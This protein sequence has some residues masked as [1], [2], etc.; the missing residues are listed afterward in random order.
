[1][2]QYRV[3]KM[4]GTFSG[5]PSQSALHELNALAQEGWEVVNVTSLIFSPYVAL[6][7]RKVAGTVEGTS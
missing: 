5:R 2:W 4:G 6:L 1:M 3:L 7:K